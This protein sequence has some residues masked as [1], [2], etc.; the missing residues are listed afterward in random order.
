MSSEK[1]GIL[2]V[3]K[4]VG[5]TSFSLVAATRRRLGVKKV[6]HAGT[7]DPFAT[8]VMVLLVGREYTKLSDSFLEQDKEYRARLLFGASTDTFDCDGVIQSTSDC[9]PT[10]DEID[11]AV[12]LFQGEIEQ[13]PPMFSAK[14]I[15]GQK[16]CD[17]ARKGKTVERAPAK[18]K[19]EMKVLHY[20][21]PYMDIHVKCS[22]GTYIRSLAHDLGVALE[23]YAHLVEL[24]RTRSGRFALSECLDGKLLDLQEYDLLP[25]LKKMA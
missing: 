4:P 8:G 2:L 14:K 11:H 3:N 18:V 20:E 15:N 19:V 22:K 21:Y 10:L 7:L 13:I 25:H 23:C 6:G 5:K 1:E 24:Q 17:L 12:A 16:L 9:V